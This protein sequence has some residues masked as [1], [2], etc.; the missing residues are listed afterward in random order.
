MYVTSAQNAAATAFP[1]APSSVA[2]H[3][4]EE[5]EYVVTQHQEQGV[6][7]SPDHAGDRYV[8]AV[9]RYFERAARCLLPAA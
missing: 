1:S 4:F 5:W 2:F 3:A 6:Q 8:A 7:R 9:A